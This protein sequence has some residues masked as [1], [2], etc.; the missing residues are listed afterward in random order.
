MGYG[1]RITPFMKIII[2]TSY[3]RVALIAVVQSIFDNRPP[4]ECTDEIYCYY[5]DPKRLLRD[6][7]MENSSYTLHV[8]CLIGYVILFWLIAYLAL[9]VRLTSEISRV[10]VNY[11]KKYFH[12]G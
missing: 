3:M 8:L 2:Y 9:R 1:Q 10:I 5:Q 7:G 4:L 12:Y 11:T 6:A